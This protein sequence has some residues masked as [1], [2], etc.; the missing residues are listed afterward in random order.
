MS[1]FS[2]NLK[3]MRE[4]RG[5]T[6]KELADLVGVNRVTYTNWENGNREPKFDKVIELAKILKANTDY[7]LGFSEKN[8]FEMTDDELV[9]G[10]APETFEEWKAEGEVPEMARQIR[11]DAEEKMPNEVVL[12]KDIMKQKIANGDN[13]QDIENWFSI[14]QEDEGYDFILYL[15]NVAKKEVENKE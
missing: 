7:L 5:Y 15:Y 2:D 12:L 10:E 3:K 11:K 14:S 1:S 8:M 13:L 4:K 6:H 9:I